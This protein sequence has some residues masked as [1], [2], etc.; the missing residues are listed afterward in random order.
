VIEGGARPV[1]QKGVCE[2]VCQIAC[3]TPEAVAV[4]VHDEATGAVGDRDGRKSAPVDSVE[5]VHGLGCRSTK[6]AEWHDGNRQ[7]TGE[8]PRVKGVD[9][10][11]PELRTHFAS[12]LVS[13]GLESS[14]E[15]HR[16][17]PVD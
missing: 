10:T 8:G 14:P 16:A 4:V 11:Q 12:D 9:Q 7:V 3:P 5:V 2:L 15:G 17:V 6:V 1:K 13:L